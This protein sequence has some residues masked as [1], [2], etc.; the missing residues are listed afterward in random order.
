MVLLGTD[1]SW[2]TYIAWT[3]FFL[4][5]S[6]FLSIDALN[7]TFRSVWRRSRYWLFRQA[8]APREGT[9]DRDPGTFGNVQAQ[10]DSTQTG[11]AERLNSMKTKHFTSQSPNLFRT[12]H[13]KARVLSEWTGDRLAITCESVLGLFQNLLAFGFWVV[14]YIQWCL[15][16]VLD[17]FG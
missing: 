11:V 1:D 7:H 17:S 6:F 12:E 9:H 5:R 10:G 2:S 3:K 4:F 15:E 14:T 16:I 13:S 8:L